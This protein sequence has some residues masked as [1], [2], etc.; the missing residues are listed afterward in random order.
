MFTRLV[1]SPP[2]SVP[3]VA[4]PSVSSLPSL[5]P[6]QRVSVRSRFVN[7]ANACEACNPGFFTESYNLPTCKPCQPGEPHLAHGR[8]TSQATNARTLT[9]TSSHSHMHKHTLTRARAYTNTRTHPYAHSLT[10]AHA[11]SLT[12]KHKRTH[13]H[14]RRPSHRHLHDTNT[15]PAVKTAHR[16]ADGLPLAGFYQES[17][18]GSA[19]VTCN[20]FREKSAYQDRVN[21]TTCIECTLSIDAMSHGIRCGVGYSLHG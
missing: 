12:H 3:L 7:D 4:H 15:K 2:P 8:N 1:C 5:P 6:F 20:G 16:A 14:A 18:G 19:C 21:A 13:T 10:H 9:H 17:R 11:H